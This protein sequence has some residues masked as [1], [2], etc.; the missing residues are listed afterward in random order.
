MSASQLIQPPQIKA[1]VSRILKTAN[2]RSSR[3]LSAFLKYVVNETL[4]GREQSLKEYVIATEVLKKS[5]DFNP[6]LDAVVRIHARRL[7]QFLKDYYDEEG[8]GDPIR[9]TMPKGR[10]IPV[11][12]VNVPEIPRS[13]PRAGEEDLAMEKIPTLVVMPFDCLQDLKRG[14]VICSVLSRDITVGLSYFDGMKVVSFQSTE[15]TRKKLKNWDEIVSSL[16]ADYIISGACMRDS[17]NLKVSVE[18]HHVPE[19]QVIWAETLVVEDFEQDELKGYD[20][21]VKKV[22]AKACG[23][24][25]IIFRTQLSYKIPNDYSALYAIYWHNRYHQDFSYE[26]YQEASAAIDKGLGVNPRNPML[27]AFKAELLLNLCIMDMPDDDEYYRQGSTL[28]S[29]AISLDPNNQ[30]AW[31][32]YAWSALLGS[33]RSE[34]NKAAEKCISINR[35]NPM[36]MGA[37]GFAH[38]C[39][40]RCEEGLA[41]M[42]ESIDLNPQYHWVINLGLCLYHIQEGKYE[43]AL[44]WARLINRPG[45]L[46]DPLLRLSA[47]GLSGKKEGISLVKKE[48]LEFSPNFSERARVIVGRFM[49]Y[50]ELED[51]ILQGL[52]Q[53]GLEIQ[54]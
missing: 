12:K 9:I 35:Y 50:P 26:S 42:L 17:G 21:L 15:N 53:A 41:M 25:G 39:V 13:L 28:V 40:G 2:F 3:I 20:T 22:V 48:L 54:T 7:R 49:I 37:V 33:N 52:R 31:Q 45:M 46:W 8:R 14:R 16:G 32:V 1:Q 10:Y 5:P 11:F 36:Y 24:F 27:L 47:M 43:D 30:H 6:Q 34:Y 4:D 19:N 23:Y 29:Q 38:Q 51:R 18:L 44:Y